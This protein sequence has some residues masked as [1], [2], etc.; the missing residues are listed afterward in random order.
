MVDRLR[1]FPPCGC[2]APCSPPPCHSLA[3]MKWRMHCCLSTLS[4]SLPFFPTVQAGADRVDA[5]AVTRSASVQRPHHLAIAQTRQPRALP[6][7]PRSPWPVSH[8]NRAVV[9]ANRLFPPPTPCWDITGAQS[10]PWPGQL[11][12]SFS[13]FS[14]VMSP[15]IAVDGE[16][17]DGCPNAGSG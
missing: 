11:R 14:C 17:R 4:H 9:R 7:S 13:L 16:S 15:S 12:L 2:H 3:S 6:S 10:S 1:V 8:A 5:V